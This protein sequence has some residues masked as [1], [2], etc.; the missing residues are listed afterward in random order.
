MK[1][2]ILLAG[3]VCLL[4]TPA[5]AE[6]QACLRV[7]QIWN[8]KAVGNQTLIVESETHQKFKLGLMGFCQGLNF[9]QTLGFK[10]IGG[11]E[12]SCLTPGD[13]VFVHVLSMRQTCPIKTIDLYTPDME[14]ADKDAAE[15]KKTQ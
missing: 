7:G 3:L 12:L 15:A 10:S 5:F 9:K 8:W 2:K 14:K 6:E 13:D 11:T 4:A 1:T